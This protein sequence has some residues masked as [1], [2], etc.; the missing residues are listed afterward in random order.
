MSKINNIQVKF[1]TLDEANK[2]IPEVDQKFLHIFQDMIE[3]VDI[4]TELEKL[5]R[6][7]KLNG[8]RE[9]FL[10]KVKKLMEMQDD[11]S[12]AVQDLIEKGLVVR[13]L[14]T[15]VVDFPTIIEGDLGYFCWKAG[16][17]EIESWH[18]VN[19]GERKPITPNLKI[20]GRRSEAENN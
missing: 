6:K 11:M 15:G 4:L 19:V 5:S 14:N 12:Q 18:P 8:D 20:L 3:L 9:A 2:M 17:S 7:K 10:E 1:Y 13:D 16:E